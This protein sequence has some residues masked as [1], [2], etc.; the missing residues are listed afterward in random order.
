MEKCRFETE[1]NVDFETLDYERLLFAAR[2]FAEAA[3][4]CVSQ[5]I[6]LGRMLEAAS[7]AVNVQIQS[8]RGSK[9]AAKITA[10]FCDDLARAAVTFTKSMESAAFTM[11]MRIGELGLSV[12]RP[13][14]VTK[15]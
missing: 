15:Q 7:K 4:Y 8:A 6:G 10:A 13:P 2:V 14:H 3:P 5:G 11:G 12:Q 1:N 9:S